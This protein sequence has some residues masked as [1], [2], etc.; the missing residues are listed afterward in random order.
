M[1]V[2]VTCADACVAIATPTTAN[3]FLNIAS[4]MT[5]K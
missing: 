1:F 5:P 2:K 3:A 4:S